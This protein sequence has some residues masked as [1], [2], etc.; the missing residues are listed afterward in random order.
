MTGT[1]PKK[2]KNGKDVILSDTMDLGLACNLKT[3]EKYF[4]HLRDGEEKKKWPSFV[5]LSVI[6]N[7]TLTPL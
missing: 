1:T 5:N 3:L 4:S 2:K 6:V 7:T